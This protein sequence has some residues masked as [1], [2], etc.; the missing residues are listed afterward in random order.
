YSTKKEAR[1]D[2]IEYIEMFYNCNRL[3]SSIGYNSPN[4]FEKNLKYKKVA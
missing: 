2:V 3:H 1:S 4:E